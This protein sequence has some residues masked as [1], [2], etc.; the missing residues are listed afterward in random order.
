MLG[1]TKLIP[2]FQNTNLFFLHFFKGCAIKMTNNADANHKD[3]NKEKEKKHDSGKP[4]PFEVVHKLRLRIF[5]LFLT[6]FPVFD[7]ST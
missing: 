7:S 2:I 4:I 1:Q 5:R 3:S 6:P